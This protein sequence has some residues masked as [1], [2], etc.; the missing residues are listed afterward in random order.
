MGKDIYRIVKV[1]GRI[2]IIKQ[3]EMSGGH[4]CNLFLTPS[5]PPACTQPN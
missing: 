5:V 1:G 2:G 4:R 3:G